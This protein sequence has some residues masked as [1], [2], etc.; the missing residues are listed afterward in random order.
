MSKRRAGLLI[1][2]SLTAAAGFLLIWTVTQVRWQEVWLALRNLRWW[3]LALLMG[4]NLLIVVLISARWWWVLRLQGNKIPFFSLVFYRLAGFGV[5]YL[6][7]GPQFGGEGW[8][9]ILLNRRHAVPLAAGSASVAL[10]KLIELLANF[11]FL[12]FG[13]LVSLQLGISP[14][15]LSANLFVPL[16]SLFL[17]PFLL[18]LALA[19]GLLPATWLVRRWQQPPPVLGKVIRLIA[20]AESLSASL[21]RQRMGAVI[22]LYFYSLA[23]W[24]V[25]VVEYWLTVR[26]LGVNVNLTHT[27]FSMTAARLAFLTPL[28]GGIGALEAAQV[29]AMQVLGLG[30]SAGLSLSLLQRGRDLLLALAGIAGGSLLHLHP[31]KLPAHAAALTAASP[32]STL[33]L[34]ERDQ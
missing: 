22:A 10:D 25:M 30:A 11:S 1:T 24:L 28:P 21:I 5:S 16:F 3:Q 29:T 6:T 7:P 13:L 27:L 34:Q 15:R 23:I 14:N 32:Y 26:F 18:F 8:L 17:I 31:I 20:N 9:V 12:A 4:L 33:S 2:L 19:S